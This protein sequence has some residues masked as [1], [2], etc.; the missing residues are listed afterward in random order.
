LVADLDTLHPS[1]W[2]AHQLARGRETGVRSHFEALDQE[3][4]GHGWPRRALTEL[5]M[6]QPG[7]GEIRLLAPALAAVQQGER[8]NSGQTSSPHPPSLTAR[9]VMF[10]DPP[11][12]LCA[13]ALA[14][15]GLD[16]GELLVVQARTPALP[17]TDSLWAL[18]Q[19]LKSGHV[20]A[21]LAWLPPRLAPER[22]RR[23]QLAASA[24][25]GPAFVVREWAAQHRP[26]A[27]P[28]R[29]TLQ[30]G[31]ADVIKLQILK[32]RGPA[33]ARPLWLPLPAVLPPLAA[34]RARLARSPEVPAAAATATTSASRLS[35]ATFVEWPV[36][37]SPSRPESAASPSSR[38]APW[39]GPQPNPA[40]AA[41]GFEA[42]GL[43][44]GLG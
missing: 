17:G 13:Q 9:P 19:A 30:P 15:L 38:S 25:D 7:I 3:L 12:P 5:L 14:G 33:L 10:F 35:S 44:I 40:L 29:L 26:S 22:L 24:H 43:G 21:V 8:Q 34:A 23:L 39:P 32:R 16:V 2:R 4:V 37:S 41:A 18:E 11:A 20:G 6:R 36:A 42:S 1:L 27:S 31:G 28:L